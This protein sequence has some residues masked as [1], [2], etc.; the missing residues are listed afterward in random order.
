MNTRQQI[1]P[2]E[3]C[4]PLTLSWLPLTPERWS[5]FE[6]LFGA[7]GACGGCWCMLW[8]L[9]RSQFEHQKGEGNRRAMQSIVESGQIPGILGFIGQAPVAWCSVAPREAFPA[10]E[11][12][13]ILRRVDDRPVWS[14]SCFF[15]RKDHRGKGVSTCMAA[16][17]VD[18][19]R[20]N[21]GSLVEAYP[22]EPKKDRTAPAFAWTGVAS[23]FRT[24]GYT[25]CARRSETRP[26]MRYRIT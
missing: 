25:E 5:D 19:V 18:Y 11:R 3:H 17:A 13:R 22:V 16:A 10:L 21:A 20:A 23:A 7:K 24:A 26:I 14:I 6:K 4:K 12:S 8:R 9:K 2:N 15:V 1:D